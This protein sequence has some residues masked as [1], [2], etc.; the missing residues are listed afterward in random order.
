MFTPHTTAEAGFLSYGYGWRI[1]TTSDSTRLVWHSGL[2][3]AYSA[4]FRHY[5]DEDVLVIFLSNLSIGGVP[6]REILVPPSRSGPPAT[7]LFAEAITAAPASL[8]G[9]RGLASYAGRYRIERAGR[10]IVAVDES[11]VVLY[12]EGQEAADALFP[13]P[14][15]S[16]AAANNEASQGAERL[17]RCLADPACQDED[18]DS[19]DPLGYARRNSAKVREDWV[20]HA[21]RLGNLQRIRSLA[22]TELRGRNPNQKVTCVRLYFAQGVV[23]EHLIWFA[24]DEIYWIPGRP[25]T[26]TLVFRPAAEGGLV[27]FDLLKQRVYRLE[28]SEDGMEL[29]GGDGERTFRA[30]REQ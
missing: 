16:V 23:D 17:G 25:T 2:D 6:M 4:M 8:E 13:P 27:G 19:I 20:A 24:D 28:L 18:L 3:E 12:T 7:A 10:L 22:T 26:T 1:Q 9:G 14:E 15:A 30:A 21:K 5:V 11:G 29:T